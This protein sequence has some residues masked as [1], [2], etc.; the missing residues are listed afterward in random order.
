MRELAVVIRCRQ[1]RAIGSAGAGIVVAPRSI[2][3]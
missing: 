2:A 1:R 3:R